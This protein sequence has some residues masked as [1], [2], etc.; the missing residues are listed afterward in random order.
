MCGIAGIFSSQKP[1][2]EAVLRA[3]GDALI[4]RGPDACGFYTESL[5][6]SADSF[7]HV[8]L[9][10][11]RLSIIDLSELAAQPM[12]NEDK[13]IWAVFNGEIYNFPSLREELKKAGHHFKSRSDT[14]VI[15]HGYEEFGW[16]ILP[17]LN[18]MFAFALWDSR[19]R[20]LLLARDRFG[21]KPLYYHH[22]SQEISFASEL[23]ALLKNPTIP[24]ELDLQA[25]GRY[26]L[27]E[28]VPAPHSLI[29]GVSKLEPAHYLLWSPDNLEI[30]RY[31]QPRFDGAEMSLTEAS[32]K[33]RELFIGAV[34]RRLLSDVPLG[35]FLSGGIDSSCVVAA[36]R[37]CLEASKIHTF[38]IGFAEKSFDE[39]HYARE[40]AQYFGT[41]HNEERLTINRML[42]ILPEVTNFLDEPLADAS[43]LPTYLL[44][45]FARTQVTVALGGDGGDELF[46][47]YDPFAALRPASIYECLPR[48]FRA[49]VEKM[50]T[51]LPSSTRNMSLDFKI[52]QF[53]KGCRYDAEVRIQAWMAAFCPNEQRVLL[54]PEAGRAVLAE[55]PFTPV[56]SLAKGADLSNP[57]QAAAHY[58]QSWYLSGD[59]MT[60][61]DRAAM[62]TSL[63]VRAPFLDLQVAEFANSLPPEMKYHRGTRKRI[64]RNMFAGELPENVFNRPKKGFGIPLT[65][66]LRKE[67]LPEMRRVFAPKR[68]ADEGLFNSE[69]I[70]SL[71]E[72]HISGRKDN[73]KPLWTLFM[74]QKWREKIFN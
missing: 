7:L 69:V 31:W 53:L 47:G 33:L 62:A 15:L 23:T 52:K 13:S 61:V 41:A 39:S 19:K 29:R 27:H 43:L 6:T 42:D 14:E 57:I 40:V 34:E 37:E 63:E 64:L 11:R 9:V 74:F 21:K 73:R 51:F 22:T 26:L 28:Y 24:K 20:Q 17:R 71:L 65:A 12:C 3:T 50:V 68:L 35:V 25:L 58:Y 4:H 38:A 36:M 67:L 48:P 45:C 1:V 2:D 55:D 32:A 5:C 44:S 46:A 16:E 30:T 49:A 54:T 18:G 70:T 59:I 72:E 66:W 56:R 60:K 8:G 10:H